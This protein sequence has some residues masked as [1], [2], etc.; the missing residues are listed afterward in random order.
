M[1]SIGWR[2]SAVKFPITCTAGTQTSK[3]CYYYTLQA[4]ESLNVCGPSVLYS[5]SVFSS[6]FS[7]RYFI[8]R[9]KDTDRYILYELQRYMW[10]RTIQL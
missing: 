7:L 10:M 9:N 6:V 1:Y 5:A 8:A 4:I 3:Q 2:K